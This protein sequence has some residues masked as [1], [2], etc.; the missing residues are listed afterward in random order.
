MNPENRK[1]N[2]ETSR[3]REE[4]LAKKNYFDFYFIIKMVKFI[5]KKK[6]TFPYY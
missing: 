1:N 5:K 3:M 2:K 4:R 6:I